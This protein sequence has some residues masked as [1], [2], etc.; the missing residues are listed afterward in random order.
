MVQKYAVGART[1]KV[2]GAHHDGGTLSQRDGQKL[3]LISNSA[4][5]AEG[6]LLPYKES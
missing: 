3:L 6:L 1:L 2:R 4:D 5:N